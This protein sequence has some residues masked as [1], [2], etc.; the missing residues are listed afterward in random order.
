MGATLKSDALSALI[1]LFSI[2]GLS[3]KCL[4]RS[5]LICCNIRP[6]LLGFTTN[7]ALLHKWPERI[8][9][10]LQ[11]GSWGHEQTDTFRLQ[12]PELAELQR[13]A[14]PPAAVIAT[15]QC[16]D[17]AAPAGV[18]AEEPHAQRSSAARYIST[19]ASNS[20]RSSGRMRRSRITSRK[21]LVL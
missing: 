19:T 11:R 6:F 3:P 10:W 16:R 7:V 4:P 17:G 13:S 14:H 15:L 5:C 8:H 2:R 18:D 1:F 12:D 21:A 9:P 20:A